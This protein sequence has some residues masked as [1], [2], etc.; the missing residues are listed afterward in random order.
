MVPPS[1]QSLPAGLH[2]DIEP[3][4]QPLR[5][6]VFTGGRI[7]TFDPAAPTVDALAVSR[8]R[9]VA[10]GEAAAVRD[11]VAADAEVVDLAGG[12]LV[13][14]LRDSH[15]HPLQGGLDQMSCD[16]TTLPVE[17]EGYLTLV[18]QHAAANP[19]LDWV[20]GGGWSLS[21]FP[22]GTPTAAMLDRAVADR[23]CFL[24]NRDRHGA[25]VNSAALARAGITAATPDPDDGRIERFPDGSPT[26]ALHEG[27]TR[28]VAD[29]MPVPD[30]DHCVRA[31]LR[32][33]RHMH[34]LGITGWH[35]AI[36]GEYLG[37]PD[38]Y[39]AYRRLDTDGALTASVT[40]A[41]WWDRNRGLEQ[42]PEMVAR[43]AE[44][45][46][47][48]R[49]RATAVKIMV[50]G[51]VESG[52]AALQL[53]YL[54]GHLCGTGKRYLDADQLR[55]A[56]AAIDAE[57]FQV[58]LHTIGDQAVRDALDAIAA[59]PDPRRLRHQL[60][61]LQVVDPEDVPRFGAL[62]AVANLQMLWACLEEQMTELVLPVLGP[63]RSGT[64]YPFASILAGGAVLGA[65]SDWP[66]STANPFEQ[67]AV[68]VNRT[69]PGDPA[70]EPFLPDERLTL[71]QA[72]AAFTVGAAWADH[73]EDRG[74][75]R[76]G[77]RA[78]LAAFDRDPYRLD[79]SELASV[80]AVRTYVDGACVFSAG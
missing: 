16:L 62:G 69:V 39:E 79:P 15:N 27:A 77:A 55:L 35:D 28:L 75:L 54:G 61:H 13:P 73:R 37:Y 9:I 57:G 24:V 21:A 60:A 29:L 25:W 17:V 76:V 52:T 78:D 80:R 66:V 46:Q 1:A 42:L 30:L 20:T 10:V 48:K 7:R 44:S 4:V 41:L 74:V 33:Q 3:V 14:G 59:L 68:G 56:V 47:G 5:D 50:D 53:P 22:G 36:I 38:P 45:L 23:P 19:A 43:R 72:L 2:A 8:G 31:L 12:L 64:Q 63:E 40:G 26:G 58:H 18:A 51:I 6:L 49:F 71:D 32:A 11:S 65:G 67:I 70:S 34:A